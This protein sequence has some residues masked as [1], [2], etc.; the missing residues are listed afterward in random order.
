MSFLSP[1]RV[2]QW[3]GR[4]GEGSY[5]NLVSLAWNL[6]GVSADIHLHAPRSLVEVVPTSCFCRVLVIHLPSRTPEMNS[7]TGVSIKARASP[8]DA[9]LLSQRKG[10]LVVAFTLCASYSDLV[11]RTLDRTPQ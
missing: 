6:P 3:H 4:G 7:M 11:P 10:P 8:A 5:S 9:S 2:T 1:I